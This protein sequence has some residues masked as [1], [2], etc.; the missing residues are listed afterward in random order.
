MS[1]MGFMANMK[2]EVPIRFERPCLCIVRAVSPRKMKEVTS[3][4]SDVESKLIFVISG[5]VPSKI[6]F[7]NQL[8]HKVTH[9]YFERV[10]YMRAFFDRFSSIYQQKVLH[11]KKKFL[12]REREIKPIYAFI[13]GSDKMIHEAEMLRQHNPLVHASSELMVDSCKKDICEVI[14]SLSKLISELLKST[15][16]PIVE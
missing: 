4:A 3:P 8:Y 12:F 16:L 5:D 11:K 9:N 15:D 2:S 14:E 13:E 7:A 1:A 6:Q 10:S